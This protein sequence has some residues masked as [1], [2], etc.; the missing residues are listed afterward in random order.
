MTMLK[1]NDERQVNAI[2]RLE[3]FLRHW[4]AHPAQ[5]PPAELTPMA[6]SAHG[7]INIGAKP[8]TAPSLLVPRG[9]QD[10]YRYIEPGVLDWV[11]F[12][13]SDLGLTTYT[14]CEGHRYANGDVDERHIGLL[15]DSDAEA[16]R[17]L[18]LH[19]RAARDLEE[20]ACELGW[21]DHTVQGDGLTLRALDIFLI[22]RSG[23]SWDAY[24]TA[25]DSAMALVIAQARQAASEP[26][27]A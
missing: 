15:V 14:S 27:T 16:D 12:A 13:V 10:F 18:A 11:A 17:V 25:L 19:E 1:L 20:T 24:F 4:Q 8:F 9:H 21:M 6:R 2:A 3:P 23:H 22:R 26:V 5:P 7:N